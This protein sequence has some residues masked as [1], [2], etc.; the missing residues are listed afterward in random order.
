[1]AAVDDAVR[2]HFTVEARARNGADFGLVRL[3]RRLEE[4]PNRRR[5]HTRK[6]LGKAP[7]LAHVVHR[8]A[9]REIE[10]R[11]IALGHPLIL[12]RHGHGVRCQ[13][14]HCRRDFDA[15]NAVDGGVMDL[16][17]DGEAALRQT[18]HSVEPLDHVHLPERLAQVERPRV[19]ARR[20]DAQ[21]PPIARSRQR[22]VSHVELDVEVGILDPVR[23]IETEGHL[24][25]FLAKT[26][27][28]MQT[29]F[30]VLQDA[31][32]RD[33]RIGRSRLVVDRQSADVQRRVRRF[34]IQE[35]RVETAKLLH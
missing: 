9:R 20:L 34:E 33:M 27:R 28:E 16:R 15:R 8:G 19:N 31:L 35:G 5:S 29:R 12:G 4:L 18:L 6:R 21:L 10:P 14:V 23:V 11:R 3:L 13:V 26:A 30:E 25:Q 17:Q 32:E 7:G 1:M 22:D 24:D 2:R